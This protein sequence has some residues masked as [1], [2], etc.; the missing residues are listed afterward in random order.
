[1]S[2]LINPDATL[3]AAP[4]EVPGIPWMGQALLAL[5]LIATGRLALRTYWTRT[6][7]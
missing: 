5:L 7:G 1:M 3:D 6:S 4:D 2:V